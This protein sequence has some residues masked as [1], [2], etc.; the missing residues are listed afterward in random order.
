M[1]KK[2]KVGNTYIPKFKS[3]YDL[4]F[5]VKNLQATR[6]KHASKIK[7]MKQQDVKYNDIMDR[8]VDEMIL[9]DVHNSTQYQYRARSDLK[10]DKVKQMDINAVKQIVNWKTR[11]VITK[12]LEYNDLPKSW[13]TAFY[14]DN[15]KKINDVMK[16]VTKE[17]IR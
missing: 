13:D 16:K 4:N 7:K 17:L 15:Y 2:C 3:C 1:A 9:S 6:D 5:K 12:A 10:K 11:E 14:I 8:F